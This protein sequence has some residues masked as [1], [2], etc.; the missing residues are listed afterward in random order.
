MFEKLG[1]HAKLV[2]YPNNIKV[3]EST[4]FDQE[5]D[6]KDHFDQYFQ[7]YT[8][9]RSAEELSRK[10]GIPLAIIEIKLKKAVRR[11]LLAI[12]SRIEGVKYYKNI[13]LTI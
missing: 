12:D 4:S 11:G 7:D 8:T 1:L 2:T 13:L 6:F 9:G 5:K 10:K 3:I